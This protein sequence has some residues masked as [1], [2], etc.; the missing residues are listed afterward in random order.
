MNYLTK[1]VIVSTIIFIQSTS[2]WDLT[3]GGSGSERANTII[4]LDNNEYLIVGTTE[5][6]GFG[7]EWNPDTYLIKLDESGDTIWT[8][9]YGGENNDEATFALKASDGY[10]FVAGFTY[11]FGAGGDFWLLKLNTEGD[12]LWTRTYG[13]KQNEWCLH[14]IETRDTCLLLIGDTQSFGAGKHGDVFLVKTDMD[15]D[16]IWTKK[17]SSDNSHS[18][19]GYYL[20]RGKSALQFED[21]SLII[22]ADLWDM[23]MQKE[24][25]WLLK[26]DE[27]GD[28]LFTKIH[29][30]DYNC[31]GNS[32]LNAQ[33]EGFIVAGYY[34]TRA[35][36]GIE[37]NPNYCLIIKLDDYGDTIWT[38][39]PVID[40]RSSMATSII[41]TD[42]NCYAIAGFTGNAFE[43]Q[44]NFF[45][46]KMN[47][48]GEVIWKRT[49][50]GSGLNFAQSVVQTPDGGYIIAGET[51]SRGNG[52]YDIFLIK[53]DSRGFEL[54]RSE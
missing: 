25:I 8:R 13:G 17:Y 23:A 1:V 48:Q 10:R 9:V 47:Q 36:N 2:A 35:N 15:G 39:K 45:L 27:N 21:G 54:E 16:T 11:S 18:E 30:V 26:L 50:G 29:G 42:D 41:L 6:Y 12:T 3:Y 52:E 4:E 28:T 53:T 24:Y 33:N 14:I 40:D 20:E 49:Y 43:G 32:F 51:N 44:A 46:L 34:N 22:L 31:G 5:S 19:E 7:E 38:S 37:A